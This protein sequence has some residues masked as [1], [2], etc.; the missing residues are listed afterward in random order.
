MLQIKAA[1]RDGLWMTFAIPE[2]VLARTVL[3]L[4]KHAVSPD[5]KESGFRNPGNFYIWNPES[6]K[7]LFGESGIQE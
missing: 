7:F 4:E 6:W 2:N 5:V 1:L 3:F